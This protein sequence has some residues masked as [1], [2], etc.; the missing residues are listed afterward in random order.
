MNV[1]FTLA[2]T[3]SVTLQ[4]ETRTGT[5][6]ST[7]AP[8][9]LDAGRLSLSWDGRAASGASAPPGAYVARVTATSSIGTLA[10]SAPFTLRG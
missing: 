2:R 1:A 6:V 8:T 7:S 3:A 10:L 9:P 4:V 5:V